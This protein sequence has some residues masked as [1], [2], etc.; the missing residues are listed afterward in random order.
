MAHRHVSM[1]I[2]HKVIRQFCHFGGLSLADVEQQFDLRES[3]KSTEKS[4]G[5][6]T[7]HHPQGNAVAARPELASQ[8]HTHERAHTLHIKGFPLV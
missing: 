6:H 5:V 3:E 8:T 2:K 4:Y 7:T 1:A